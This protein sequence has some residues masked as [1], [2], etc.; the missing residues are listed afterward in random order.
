MKAVIRNSN[1][2]ATYEAPTIRVSSVYLPKVKL[3]S[4]NVDYIGNVIDINA[5]FDFGESS[6]SVDDYYMYWS[7]D[8]G[9]TF[10]EE[11][12]ST[13]SQIQIQVM[14]RSSLNIFINMQTRRIH[15]TGKL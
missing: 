13:Q 10:N 15:I 4:Q 14:L 6:K 12:P 9:V 1:S 5:D 2:G 3:V 11:V 7:E 8:N